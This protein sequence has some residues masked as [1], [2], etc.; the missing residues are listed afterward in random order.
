MYLIAQ[1][2]M[3]VNI[4][5]AQLSGKEFE[6]VP[7]YGAAETNL[8]S[9]HEVVGSIPRLTQWVKNLALL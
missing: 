7:L 2:L 5:S 1:V 6:G 8:T 3:S 9:N 4:L